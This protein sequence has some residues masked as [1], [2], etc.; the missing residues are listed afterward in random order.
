M[1]RTDRR[2]T[3]DQDVA[4]ERDRKYVYDEDSDL[5]LLQEETRHRRAA[6]VALREKEQRVEDRAERAREIREG[7]GPDKDE[8]ELLRSSRRGYDAQHYSRLEAE[9]SAYTGR[10]KRPSLVR[11]RS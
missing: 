3:R 1:L 9:I 11:D 8:Y 4:R 2:R 5:E 10:K 7:I 6:V